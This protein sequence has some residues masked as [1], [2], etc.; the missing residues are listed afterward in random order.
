MKIN[1]LKHLNSNW[2][3]SI[4]IRNINKN[5]TIVDVKNSLLKD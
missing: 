3:D 4:M 2:Y 5:E 1:G